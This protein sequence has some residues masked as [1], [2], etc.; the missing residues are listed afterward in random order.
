MQPVTEPGRR[1]LL[2]QIVRFSQILHAAGVPVSS[3]NLIVLCQSLSFINI[4]N[5]ED[6]YAAS[7][8]TLLSRHTDIP[9]FDRIFREF[10]HSQIDSAEEKTSAD[11][12]PDRQKT[13]AEKQEIQPDAVQQT[14]S[15]ERQQ[16]SPDGTVQS[17]SPAALLMQKD[18]EK[19]S[20]EEIAQARVLLKELVA[21]LASYRS[22]RRI[23]SF[24]G[25]EI[26]L[27]RMLRESAMYGR[28]SIKLLYRKR[29][30][31]KT[32][33]LLL[34]D[35]SG[36]MERYSRFLIQF[37]YAMRQQLTGLEVAVFSTRM[38]VI[39][40]YLG[41]QD[42]DRSLREVTEKVHDWAGGTR[43]GDSL[44]EFNNRFAVDLDRNRTVVVIL[45]D[46][47]DRG[48]AELMREEIEYLSRHAHKLLWL[49]PLLGNSS[50]EPLCRGMQTALPFIDYFLSAHNLESLANLIRILRTILRK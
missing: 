6:F 31:K 48:D 5:E 35:V 30:I 49:N 42:I 19:M 1:H 45:S 46:G 13:D 2:D 44:H 4:R 33:L 29:Q 28:D 11:D 18:F 22:R 40:D 7:R 32:R 10:W 24:H 9:V 37:I 41:R 26:N 43:I 27:R 16:T 25:K 21:L 12:R 15:D 8:T 36:S 47:W 23:A 50:Y 14:R 3:S 17:Y 38:T 39:T 34:C 20:E